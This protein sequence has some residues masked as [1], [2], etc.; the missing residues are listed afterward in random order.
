MNV[1]D[2]ERQLTPEE[3]ARGAHRQFVG[4]LWEELGALQHAFLKGRGLLPRHRLA[5]IGCGALRGGLHFI[6]YLDEGRYYG[7]DTN[8]SLLDAGRRELALAKL[9]HKRPSLFVTRRFEL[10]QFA[11]RFDFALAV[12]VFTHLPM[13]HIVKCLVEAK[14]ALLPGAPFY[15]TFFESPSDAHVEPLAHVPGD[16]VSYFDMDPYHYSPD[17]IRFLA[18]EAGVAA[19]RIGEWGHPRDQR[20]WSFRTAA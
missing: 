10:A 17:E 13:N 2:Y 6:A 15:A 19:E 12:S 8:E 3:I 18:R 20:M 5:D 9:E 14:R 7:I 11:T 4:G 1:N 16:V